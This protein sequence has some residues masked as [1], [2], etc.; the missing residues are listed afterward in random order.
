MTEG[1]MSH[2]SCSKKRIFAQISFINKLIHQNKSA[3]RQ[4]GFQRSHSRERNQIRDARTFQTI[5]IRAVINGAG[6]K[7]MPSPMAWQKHDLKAVYFAKSQSVRGLA[8]RASH[9]LPPRI[10]HWHIINARAA[11]NSEN[12]FSH[13]RKLNARL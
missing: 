5:Q 1:H 8:P 13:E 4:F 12:G 10:I 9:T 2:T 7:N 11:D 3:R 6:G